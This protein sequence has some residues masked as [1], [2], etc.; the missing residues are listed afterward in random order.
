MKRAKAIR[1]CL[2]LDP[3][4]VAL[5]DATAAH[6]GKTRAETVVEA[7]RVL[8]VAVPRPSD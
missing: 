4:M 3:I 6:L 2:D 8:F 1:V 7:L 5:L